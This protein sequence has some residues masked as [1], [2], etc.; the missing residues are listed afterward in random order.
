MR[1]VMEG[2]K[3]TV[4]VLFGCLLFA[5]AFPWVLKLFTFYFDYFVWAVKL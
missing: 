3:G 5:A 2:W 1:N 4:I